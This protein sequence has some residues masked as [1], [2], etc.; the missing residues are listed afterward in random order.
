MLESVDMYR[1]FALGAVLIISLIT[2]GLVL[3]KTN[4]SKSLSIEPTIT[5][6]QASVT[7]VMTPKPTNTAS[8]NSQQM[9]ITIQVTKDGPTQ[10]I[11]LGKNSVGKKYIVGLNTYIYFH[12]DSADFT[13]DSNGV[14]GSVPK[15]IYNLPN[16]I[17]SQIKAIGLGTAT[18]TFKSS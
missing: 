5:L 3:I 11:D 6:P 9:T 17:C 12:C 15:G 16:N 18:I 4:S 2:L 7:E 14:L 8:P 10:T 13:Y 1:P